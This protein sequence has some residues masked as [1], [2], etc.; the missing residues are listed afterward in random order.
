MDLNERADGSNGG[1]FE[2]TSSKE[3]HIRLAEYL[4]MYLWMKN[5]FGNIAF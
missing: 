1:V 3:G 2:I 5:R 4:W